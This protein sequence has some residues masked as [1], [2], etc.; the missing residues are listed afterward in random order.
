MLGMLIKTYY[1]KKAGIDPKKIVVVS[2]MPCTAKKF[3][4]TRPEMESGVDYVLTTRE[5]GRLV[6]MKKVDFAS[7]PDEE[8][9]PA[10]GISTGA[11]VIFGA[12]GGVMEAAL[13]TAH[14]FANGK[15]L[16]K[17]EINDARG[18]TGIKEGKITL[19]GREIRYACAHGGANAR[20][21]MEQK[22]R[23][24]FIEIMAC[25]GGCIGGGG[26]PIYRNPEVLRKRTDAIYRAD[27][28]SRF[29]CSHQ[30]PVVKQIYKEMLGEP[31]S[32]EAER[33]LHTHYTKRDRF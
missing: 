9:D 1:A 16:E 7:L 6:K 31:L 27:C 4:S 22:D 11:G 30:N 10:L 14:F 3:E 29:R 33:L 12:T 19:K 26:Q 21:L 25:P 18:M 13:R 28:A 24:D 32:D 17:V 23:Y 20:K 2:I 15:E 8:F 5:L